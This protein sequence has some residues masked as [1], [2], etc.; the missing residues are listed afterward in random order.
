MKSATSYFRVVNLEK[1][2]H[3]K[4]RAPP[5]I[6]LYASTLE[7]YDFGRLQDASK[8]HLCAIWLLASRTG[9]KIP[10][11]PDWIAKRINATSK[12][13]LTSLQAAGFIELIGGASNTLATCTQSALS[14]TE[15]R[16]RQRAEAEESQSR[17]EAETESSRGQKRQ[18][19]SRHHRYVGSVLKILPHPIRRR[20]YPQRQGQLPARPQFC[21]RVPLEEAPAIAAFYLSHNNAY[22][23]RTSHS[24]DALLKDAEKL[25][26]EW[27][28][29]RHRHRTESHAGRADSNQFQQR[30]KGNRATRKGEIKPKEIQHDPKK[31]SSSRLIAARAS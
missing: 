9:N 29:G 7:D 5:W 31:R 28:T 12:V 1:F 18:A 20:A 19:A 24:T 26:T 21:K 3:Y 22:Y 27:Q 23:L 13:D 2:Q 17:G 30:R 10:W 14:E 11:D 8:M 6:K 25:R 4:D 15:Q 16:E